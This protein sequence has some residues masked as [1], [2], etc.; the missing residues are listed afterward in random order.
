M[1][2]VSLEIFADAYLD[3][4]VGRT[5]GFCYGF[6]GASGTVGAHHQ[7]STRAADAAAHTFATTNYLPCKFLP[8]IGPHLLPLAPMQSICSNL[9][10][11][12]IA[13]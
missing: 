10:H 2:K 3:R 11:I 7:P 4:H 13:L 8:P 5:L 12:V 6:D 9:S 1:T